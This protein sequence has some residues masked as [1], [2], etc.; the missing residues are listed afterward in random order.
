MDRITVHAPLSEY[1]VLIGEGL[2]GQMGALLRQRGLTGKVGIVTNP[3]VK[4]LYARRVQEGLDRAGLNSVVF[5]VP[6]GEA[7]KTLD[8]VRGLYEQF[9]EAGLDRTSTLVAL[10]GGVIGDTAGFAAATYMRG[11]PLVQVPTTLLAMVDASIGGKVGVDLPR[12]KNLVGAFK[13]PA[14][15]VTDPTT[16][17]TLPHEEFRCGL[18]EVVKAGLIGSPALF[19]HLENRGAE[20]LARV[21]REAIAVKV[22]IVEEDPFEGG[23]RAILNLGHTFGHALEALSGYGLRHGYAVSIGMVVATRTAVRLGL[24]D[25][26]VEARLKAL[27]ERFALPMAYQGFTPEKIWEAMA[28]DK[29]KRGQRLHFVLPLRIGEVVV[30]DQ[31]PKEV[32]LQALTERKGE[33]EKIM[34]RHRR[35][36]GGDQTP[37]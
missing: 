16:L 29:K 32:V 11:L 25:P 18:A 6:D 37:P 27:L 30:T 35:K 19:A 8:T 21:L 9:L 23:R 12:G 20:P 24:C 10:G 13:Q 22:A 3:V 5:T 17:A 28:S 36:T 15:V 26:A 7:Y 1:E 33:R 2:L 4:G 34:T 31:V 14:L